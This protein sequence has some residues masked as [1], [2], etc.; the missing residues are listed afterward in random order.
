[1][2]RDKAIKKILVVDD[3]IM[4]AKSIVTFLQSAGYGCESIVDPTRTLEFLERDGIDLVILDIK[5]EGIDG[6]SLLG[7]MVA[8]NLKQ[9]VIV[10]TG[11]VR[12]YEYGDIIQA[13]A[14]DFIAKP[15]LMSELKARIDR[16]ERERTMLNELQEL[17]TTLGVLLTRSEEDKDKLCSDI[18]SNVNELI[19][20][21]LNKLK[22]SY[23]NEEQ[24][25]C[26][27]ILELNLFDICSPL[28]RCLSNQHV[29]LSS[30][31]VQ[32]A[33]LIK[34]GKGNK[35]IASILG[36]SVNTI[37][38]HRYRLRSKLGLKGEKVNLRSYLNSIDF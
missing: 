1:M 29:H 35:E 5:M 20:P 17:K 10:M 23:L 15:F 11:Y 30:M 2:S 27:E 32:V 6:L 13:G 31:E 3:E 34:S 36:V 38:T 21:F 8:R 9:D 19:L 24:K 28:I 18:I 16:I 14:A 25:T 7:K 4:V 12:D 33:N 22:N 26:L 37:L